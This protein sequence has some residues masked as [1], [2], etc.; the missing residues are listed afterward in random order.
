[1]QVDVQERSTRDFHC[2]A[3]GVFDDLQVVEVMA[4]PDIQDQVR[5]REFDA[6]AL[7]VLAEIVLPDH[8]PSV[9]LR[10][11][12]LPRA[13]E[14]VVSTAAERR[15]HLVVVV[16]RCRVPS[17]LGANEVAHASDERARRALLERGG[18][19]VFV[20]R[21]SFGGAH[22]VPSMV[23]GGASERSPS[24]AT[25]GGRPRPRR[26]Y[27][28]DA[29]AQPRARRSSFAAFVACSARRSRMSGLRER[30]ALR[31]KRR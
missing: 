5:A 12:D 11:G 1:M 22:A 19:E 3:H 28:S 10:R 4:T 9:D 15:R 30:A 8:P 21:A 7:D 16:R 14:L 29:R 27:R 20:A 6:V 24:A 17:D 23:A 25:N 18:G 13:R 2:L 26:S 31:S